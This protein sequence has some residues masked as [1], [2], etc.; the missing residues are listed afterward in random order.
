VNQLFVR[1]GVPADVD[2][3]A[4][5]HRLVNERASETRHL[6]FKR[7]LNHIDDLAD[8]LSALANIGGGVL[9]IG[10]GTD[11][12]DCAASLHDQDLRAVEQ[13]V[14]Q[15]AR[16]GID[17]P[18]RVEPTL[19]PLANDPSRGF[20]V[21]AVPPS[22][23]TPHISAKKGRV[24]HRVGTHNK[25]MTR[26][27]LGATFA[28]GGDLF[29]IEFGLARVSGSSSSVVCELLDSFAG[30]H[31]NLRVANT[32]TISAMD[33]SIESTTCTL[34][35]QREIKG[36]VENLWDIHGGILDPSY[37]PIRR[38]PAGADVVLTCYR[39]WNDP[40]Q[41]VLQIT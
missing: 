4:G 35:W 21:V 33:I 8:D 30:S 25:P 32:G 37:L 40:T 18:L 24:L 34:T 19:V 10:V 14:V 13:Q 20:V 9:I 17:E 29:A 15:A 3:L 5:I 23:R 31:N 2:T 38:L 41:D 27:E 16:E 11:R 36:P 6:D 22:D 26:R 39:E 28:A 1:L 12:A 7:Q